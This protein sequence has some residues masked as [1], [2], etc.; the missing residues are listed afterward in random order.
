MQKPFNVADDKINTLFNILFKNAQDKSFKVFEDKTDTEILSVLQNGNV[1]FNKTTTDVFI[2]ININ[3]LLYKRSISQAEQQASAYITQSWRS[4][5]EW[6]RVY[7][8]GW[9]EQGGLAGVGSGGKTI[10]LH[11]TMADTNYFAMASN[12]MDNSDTASHDCRVYNKTKTQITLGG[13]WVSSNN[14]GTS[15]CQRWWTVKGIKE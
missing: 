4:G 10:N 14:K 1:G 11:I 2:C 3:G 9:V 15:D 13:H 7:S 12:Y 6:Y 8:D 5:T